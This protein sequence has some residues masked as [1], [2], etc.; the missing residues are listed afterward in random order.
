MNI[1]RALYHWRESDPVWR[2]VHR[3]GVMVP[4]DG[5]DPCSVGVPT[6]V[7]TMDGPGTGLASFQTG[8]LLR[9]RIPDEGPPELT[10]EFPQSELCRTSYARMP[11]GVEALVATE[12]PSAVG[13]GPVS[14]LWL[15]RDAGEGWADLSHR[16]PAEARLKPRT[17]T[18]LMGVLVL[19]YEPR[20][21]G[22]L[23]LSDAFDGV[24]HACPSTDVGSDSQ[25][26]AYTGEALIVAGTPPTTTSGL[27]V[28][29][30]WPC[31]TADDRCGVG[32]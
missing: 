24:L 7:L 21:V 9:Y 25:V 16:L 5:D 20:S 31:S 32:R 14:R 6:L 29:W 18:E 8:P 10:L 15:R 17:L 22:T 1:D 27:T 23:D 4:P 19:P 2:F 12:Q 30:L 11:D 3:A 26:F 28:D 13:L